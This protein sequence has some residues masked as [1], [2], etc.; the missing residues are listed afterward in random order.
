MAHPGQL[1]LIFRSKKKNDRADAEKLAKLLFLGEVPTVYVPSQDVRA[2]RQ[3]VEYRR[4]LIAK[5]TRTKNA[6]RA[7]PAQRQDSGEEQP[8]RR[9]L[10][11]GRI[12]GTAPLPAWLPKFDFH[13]P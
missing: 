12:R 4:R 10:G 6:L 11:D 7:I 9:R 13:T 2:W 8:Q 5:R 3:L 1:R